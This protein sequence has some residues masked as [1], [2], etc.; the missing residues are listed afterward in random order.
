L[1]DEIARLKN[2]FR[3]TL[4]FPIVSLG[5]ACSERSGEPS[6]PGNVANST[7]L[8]DPW[9]ASRAL[10]LVRDRR[11]HVA[12][13][14]AHSRIPN[15]SPSTL[16]RWPPGPEST[17]A[18]IRPRRWSVWRGEVAR[19]ESRL[20]MVDRL[21]RANASSARAEPMD[22]ATVDE[23]WI[24]V[25]ANDHVAGPVAIASAIVTMD[26]A[27]VW[28]AKLAGGE[29]LLVNREPFHGDPE[30]RGY[31]GVPVALT[32]G[33]N[34]IEVLEAPTGFEFELWRPASPL[35]IAWWDLWFPRN[36][37]FAAHR[38]RADELLVP[39]FNASREHAASMLQFS[40]AARS[41]PTELEG[42]QARRPIVPL[43]LA[44]HGAVWPFFT[45]TVDDFR[46]ELVYVALSAF[47]NPASEADRRVIRFHATPASITDRPS[48]S[49]SEGPICEFIEGSDVS[50]QVD[51]G[52]RRARA[53]V[54]GTQGDEA[55]DRAL[56]ALA[57]FVQQRLWYVVDWTPDVFSDV[58]CEEA[59]EGLPA[60]ILGIGDEASNSIF[61]AGDGES[62]VPQAARSEREVIGLRV[63]NTEAALR[64]AILDP[65]DPLGVGGST[66]GREGRDPR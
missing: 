42:S 54:Y 25:D 28:M 27:G 53:I 32:A 7:S 29:L 51:V 59:L 24:D 9:P 23:T 45:T 6:L 18:S 46:G 31:E 57:R 36:R 66:V 52:P 12:I 16:G 63:S 55:T 21:L 14:E 3:T 41:G 4:A 34:R 38:D 37:E 17:E 19:S 65:L 5:F 47:S 20:A 10:P 8:V 62:E 43:G 15:R 39:I 44:V 40:R 60:L 13:H 11:D 1:Q 58:E 56:L 48:R 30:R 33:E 61:E 22:G 49:L 64:I 35:V 26:E 2:V 50:A